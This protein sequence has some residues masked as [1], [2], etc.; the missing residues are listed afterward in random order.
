MRDTQIEHY[1][2]QNIV[3]NETLLTSPFS[4]TPS[5][6]SSLAHPLTLREEVDYTHPLYTH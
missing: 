3:K 2:L 1:S 6:T 4:I 5:L